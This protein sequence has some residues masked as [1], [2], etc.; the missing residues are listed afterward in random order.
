MENRFLSTTTAAVS[1]PSAEG[2]ESRRIEGMAF[3]YNEWS[4]PM[5]GLM[6]GKPITFVERILPGAADEADMSDVIARSEHSNNYILARKK[7]GEGTLDVELREKGLWY[8]FNSPNT[9][10]G[11]DTLENVKLR[12][13]DGS[14]FAFA[15]A[16]K[17]ATM[18]KREDGVY[19][20]DIVKMKMIG[21]VSPT[22]QPAYSQTSAFNRSTD[23]SNEIEEQEQENGPSFDDFN[24]RYLINK[25]S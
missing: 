13:V 18:R 23:F 24:A 21:D 5:R 9:T 14:S 6:N 25:N 12:N 22:A 20:R 2:E 1:S 7:N 4:M 17:G 11:N 10:A 8:G 15:L 16:E 19:E 3:V